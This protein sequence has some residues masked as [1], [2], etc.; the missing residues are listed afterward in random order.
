MRSFVFVWSFWEA[1]T[2][3]RSAVMPTLDQNEIHLHVLRKNKKGLIFLFFSLLLLLQVDI[4]CSGERSRHW[5][6]SAKTS[7][8]WLQQNI[9][10]TFAKKRKKKKEDFAPPLRTADCYEKRSFFTQEN[11]ETKKKGLTSRHMD[12]AKITIGY[13]LNIA[14][15]CSWLFPLSWSG[16]LIFAA[17]TDI[18]KVFSASPQFTPWRFDWLDW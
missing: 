6:N 1:S 5:N 7:F 16:W 15:V 13:D 2:V 4:P 8:N 17:V 3:V 14:R 12:F 11:S 9:E 18:V 10:Q